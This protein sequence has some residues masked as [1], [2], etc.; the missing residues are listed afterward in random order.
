MEQ[1]LALS[2][3]TVIRPPDHRL[4]VFISST[5]KELAPEREVV[6]NALLR[7]HLE[8]VMFEAGARPHPA[9]QLYQAYLAQSHIFIGIY[10]ES[11]GWAGDGMDISGLEDEYNLSEGLPRLI[12]I[13]GPAPKREPGLERM[14][15][16]VR[17]ASMISY[18][19][20]SSV[21]ELGSLV[22]NDLALLLA[23]SYEAAAASTGPEAE[24]TQ[25]TL[26]NLPHPRNPLLGREQE[27]ARVSK[28]LL[29]PDIGVVTLSG[30][31]G[32]GKSRL[33]L[34]AALAVRDK[35]PDGA[36]LVRLSPVTD[37]D[38]VVATIAET[39][40]LRDSAQGVSIDEAL[41]KYLRD[42]HMLLV[43]D[44][45][46]H[47]LEAAPK[48]AFIGEACPGAKMLVTSRTSL[49]LRGEKEQFVKTLPIPNAEEASECERLSEFA[50]IQLLVQRT[51]SVLPDFAVCSGNCE[52]IGEI[53]RR[54][55]GLPLAL[56]L[57]AARLRL[58]TPEQLLERLGRRFDIL[59]GGTR[60]LP[61]RQQTLRSAID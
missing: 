32:V 23:E 47:V 42:K 33:A 53:A 19:R 13:K 7:L 18:K 49:H 8:P 40:G 12:Y 61:R 31:A 14:L 29:R 2:G 35:F 11:Y 34:E 1:Q 46:E 52:A 22:E 6:R 27:L 17:Q 58:L 20:F 28:W 4:R 9:R 44:N 57:A 60:D 38:R 15:D 56:E 55:D 41:I 39:L 51:R 21:E 54:L 10:W 59:N 3:R 36:F 48:I 50:S 5:L 43:L 26:T 16:R 25:G 37:A 45:F 24:L 30:A